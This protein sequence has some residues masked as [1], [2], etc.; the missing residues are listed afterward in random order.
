VAR[1]PHARV[2]G[3]LLLLIGVLGY[4]AVLSAPAETHIAGMWPVGL[5]SG[6]MV[7]VTRAHLPLTAAS[8]LVLAFA[9]IALGGYPT[10]VAAGFAV[11][12]VLEGLVTQ[13]VLGMRWGERR[14]LNDDLDLGRYTVAAVLG[15][16]TGALL[17]TLTSV[18]TGFGVPVT[19]AM[20][21]FV[22]HLASQLMLLA[23]FMEEARHPGVGGTTERVLRWS[24]TL[25]ATLVAF[26]PT[27]LPAALFF[28]P[29]CSAGPRCGPRCARRCGS[30]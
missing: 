29:P 12:I 26:V 7:Y 23:F 4:F 5:A 14:R 2:V 1:S 16:A 28:I 22:T 8:V 11:S 17:F 27:T 9:T 10:V 3:P 24:L 18:V 13:H 21:A 6:L 30:C 15:A 19:V 20:A 25:V